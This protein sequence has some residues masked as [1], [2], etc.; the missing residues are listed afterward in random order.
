MDENED[1]FV[2]RIERAVKSHWPRPKLLILNFPNNPTTR[3]VNLSFFEKV[4]NLARE[5]GASEILETKGYLPHRQALAQVAKASVLLLTT[6]DDPRVFPAK[7]FEYLRLGKPILG[8]VPQRS[9]IA[10]FLRD[11]KAQAVV[12]REDLEGIK[13]AL[14]LACSIAVKRI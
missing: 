12:E 7:V 8:V 2:D 1:D 11:V 9:R 13:Q 14:E 3:V 10:K 5:Y 4:V 6:S